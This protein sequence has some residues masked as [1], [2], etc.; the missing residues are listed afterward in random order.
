MHFAGATSDA[1][2]SRVKTRYL[3]QITLAQIILYLIQKYYI[4]SVFML[5]SSLKFSVKALSLTTA[6]LL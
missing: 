5:N 1:L 6:F 4:E 2:Q 3:V